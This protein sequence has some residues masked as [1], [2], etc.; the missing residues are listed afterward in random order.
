MVIPRVLKLKTRIEALRYERD[1]SG[2][3]DEK[4]LCKLVLQSKITKE[5]A[6]QILSVHN[7][8]NQGKRL[9]FP[10]ATFIQAGEWVESAPSQMEGVKEENPVLR[11]LSFDRGFV[12][13]TKLS[14]TEELSE[15][16][17]RRRIRPPLRDPF[18][19]RPTM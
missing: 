7:Q 4:Q 3:D 14:N 16:D 11:V 13:D 15:E 8:H 1:P 10:E 17:V 18:Q 12:G 19:T 5:N 9:F 2:S 6:E